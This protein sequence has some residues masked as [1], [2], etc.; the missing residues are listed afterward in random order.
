MEEQTSAKFIA[1]PSPDQ[2]C[3]LVTR[4]VSLHMIALHRAIE[5]EQGIKNK[6]PTT[7]YAVPSIAVNFLESTKREKQK[8]LRAT[9]RLDTYTRTR[10]RATRRWRESVWCTKKY[11]TPG[12]TQRGDRVNHSS[13]FEPQPMVIYFTKERP[14]N[15]QD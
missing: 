13:K 7:A 3:L 11:Y 10:G 4:R 1:T 9:S 12:S 6:E 2:T 8:T 15:Q 14:M 5:V